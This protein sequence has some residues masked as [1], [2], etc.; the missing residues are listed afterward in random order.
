VPV[1]I[2]PQ[3]VLAHQE[4]VI[5]V[6]V[7]LLL[8]PKEAIQKRKHFVLYQFFIG[9]SWLVHLVNDLLIYLII[10]VIMVVIVSFPTLPSTGGCLTHITCL[11]ML[12]VNV[13][14]THVNI[15]LPRENA[16]QVAL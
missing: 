9:L 16:L 12:R 6:G 2:H 1:I 14:V 4:R 8:F 10:I 5:I 7:S 13:V 11:R 3:L 15:V